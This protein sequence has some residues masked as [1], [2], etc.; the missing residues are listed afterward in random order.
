MYSQTSLGSAARQLVH[1]NL[2]DVSHELEPQETSTVTQQKQN[3][4]RKEMVNKGMSAD[5]QKHVLRQ[6][7]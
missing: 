6:A 2:F 4:V 3:C 7:S 1:V 5:L